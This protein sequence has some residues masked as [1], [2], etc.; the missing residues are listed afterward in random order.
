[1]G[2]RVTE[3]FQGHVLTREGRTIIKGVLTD[4]AAEGKYFELVLHSSSQQ[5]N[6]TLGKTTMGKTALCGF[7]QRSAIDKLGTYEETHDAFLH[8]A[9]ESCEAFQTQ[10]QMLEF[11]QKKVS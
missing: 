11:G 4:G 6:G 1:M 9:G 7:L 5:L 10:E 2:N 8:T 3:P